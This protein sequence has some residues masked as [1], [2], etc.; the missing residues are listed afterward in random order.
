MKKLILI[1]S[2]AVV[3]ALASCAS[4]ACNCTDDKGVASK[5]TETENECAART[6]GVAFAGG[7]CEYK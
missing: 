4:K 5:Y 1:V 3:S 2:I 7:K 6:I